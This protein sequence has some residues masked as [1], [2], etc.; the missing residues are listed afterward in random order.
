MIFVETKMNNCKIFNGDTAWFSS[1][2]SQ[3]VKNLW[4]K[5][6]YQNL[7]HYYCIDQSFYF[8]ASRQELWSGISSFVRIKA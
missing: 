4:S 6:T 7:L 5:W 2:V 1:S 3:K 8:T